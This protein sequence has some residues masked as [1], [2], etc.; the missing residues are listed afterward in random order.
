MNRFY[1][2]IFA[3]L[4][5]AC[6]ETDSEQ[7]K[8]DQKM[9]K[10]Q[11]AQDSHSF[12]KPNEVAATHLSLDVEVDFDNSVISGTATHRLER[13][14]GN[15]VFF[16]IRGL[17]IHG[18]TDQDGDTLNFSITRGNKRGDGLGIALNESTAE[19]NIN[20][21]TSS[22]AAAL[23]WLNPEQTLGKTGPF[24]FTQ[25]QAILTRSWVP[26]QDTP[27]L[28]ITYDANVKVPSNLMAVMSATNPTSKNQSGIYSFRMDQPIPP[29]LM[30]LAVGDLKFEEVGKRT[31]VYAEP[32]MLEKAVYEFADVEKMLIAAED[33]YGPYKWD[34]YDI[35]VLPPSFPFG[36]MENPR[37]TFA[38]PTIIAGD[39]SLTSLIAHEL[40]HSW[41][42]NLVTNATWD[43][44]W[45][46]EG[47]TVYF[48]KRIMEALYGKDYAEM[49]NQLGLQDLKHT[50][51]DLGETS[52]D[53][54][55]KLDLEGRD[56]DAGM[57][58]IAYEKGFLFLRML[59][60][61]VGR[62][63]FDKFL[64]N[65]FS[66]NAFKTMTTERFIA[67]LGENLLSELDEKPDVHEW[68]FQPGIPDNFPKPN[69]S[70]FA[71]VDEAREAWLSG[72]KAASKLETKDWSTHEWLYFIRGLEGGLSISK[73]SEL[74][75]AFGFTETGNSEIAAAWY[76][77]AIQSNYRKAFPAME[78][79]LVSVGRR[80]FL[81][82]LYQKLSETDEHLKWAK[83][84]YEKAR[85][86]YHSVSTQTIDEI[87]KWS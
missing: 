66:E 35:L 54:H 45:L 3:L 81:E 28:R 70:L 72:E 78:E 69:S 63:R 19:V 47:F 51:D 9:E 14:G 50:I 42:G 30:A 27:A 76:E 41:S 25:G 34:R 22:D 1:I 29:Y 87:L 33:L 10:P 20:Y 2:V 39:R 86:N 40:A 21:V 59:E 61:K 31:G 48:E 79:F 64:R 82:P 74:D 11:Y 38:T 56:P 53:T 55:L 15:S 52:P 58:D 6:Q 32:A 37:L 67:Y 60:E 68:I 7:N 71:K 73:M 16:D 18:V 65:Y 46:N 5:T 43:D 84:V 8:S 85:P 12:S 4:A 17:T 80:K 13:N 57:T 23:L 36:G 77:H 49:L 75:A 44:F 83:E 26:I 62:E 24:L